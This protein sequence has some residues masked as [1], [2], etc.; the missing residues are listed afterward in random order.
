M[1]HS[2]LGVLYF[3]RWL[4]GATGAEIDN[5]WENSPRSPVGELQG[6]SASPK[7]IN[8]KRDT[9]HSVCMMIYACSN[10]L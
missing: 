6:G 5:G 10:T 1:S 7:H 4:R 9:L 3:G 2:L 8:E